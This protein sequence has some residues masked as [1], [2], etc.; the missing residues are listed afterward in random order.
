MLAHNDRD[1]VMNFEPSEYMKKLIFQSA[2]VSIKIEVASGLDR[3][4]NCINLLYLG[5]SKC[6]PPKNFEI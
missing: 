1:V 5:G 4:T 6:V 2:G 3:V